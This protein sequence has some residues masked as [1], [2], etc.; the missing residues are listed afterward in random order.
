MQSQGLSRARGGERVRAVARSM[1][2]VSDLFHRTG[3]VFFLLYQSGSFLKPKNQ[4]GRL[5]E[6]KVVWQTINQTSH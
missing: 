1:S 3:K 6:S 2:H 5:K 4:T